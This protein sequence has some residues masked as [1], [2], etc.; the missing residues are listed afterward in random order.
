MK[1]LM[2]IFM[3][4]KSLDRSPAG[5]LNTSEC[6]YRRSKK[7]KLTLLHSERSNKYTI[8]AFLRTIELTWCINSEK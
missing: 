5:I 4:G 2:M 6:K 3:V 1:H 8:L 7:I